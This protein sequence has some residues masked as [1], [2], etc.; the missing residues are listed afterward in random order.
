MLD[1]IRGSLAEL[2]ISPKET[3]VYLAMLELGPS[4]VQDIAKKAGVNRST[5]YVMIELLKKRGLISTFEK[6]KKVFFA[7]E[8]PQRLTQT[9]DSEIAGIEAKR[10]RL[11]ASIPRLMAIF[12]SIADKPRI[13]FFEGEEAIRQIRQ[14]MVQTRLPVWEI[15][16]VDESLKELSKM[17]EKSRLEVSARSR[18]RILMA[19]KPG[20]VPPFFNA[21]SFEVREIPYEKYPFTGNIV[22]VG[23]C[24]Y[25]FSTKTVGMGVIIENQEM[26]EIF[27]ALYEALWT[28]AKP[29]NPSLEWREQGK[30]V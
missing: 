14:E 20:M 26:T 23:K 2:G 3:D 11:T 16:A 10:E 21:D 25:V 30:R 15:V 6:G 4:S 5:T 7:A 24:L 8:S 28:N 18:G 29:W 1:D 12:N 9:L 17:A 22:L 27:R 19:L 13:R